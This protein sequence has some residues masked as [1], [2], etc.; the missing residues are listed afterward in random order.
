MRG[1]EEQDMAATRAESSIQTLDSRAI[2]YKYC[3]Q[4]CV[5]YIQRNSSSNALDLAKTD[6]SLDNLLNLLQ[7]SKL[8]PVGC[9]GKGSDLCDVDRGLAKI[10]F[11]DVR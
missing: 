7:G 4:A 8:E 10:I 2:V 9:D 6:T 11:C 1:S 5:Y 3:K